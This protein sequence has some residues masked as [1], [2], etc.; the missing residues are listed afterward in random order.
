MSGR[1]GAGRWLAGPGAQLMVVALGLVPLALLVRDAL[2]GGLGVNPVEDITH[3]T[4]DWTLRL[5]LGTLAVTP[6][7][8]L[9]GLGGLTRFRRTLGLLTY[10][11]AWLHFLTFF[12]LDHSLRFDGLAEDIVKRPYI[13]VGFTTFLLLSPL[14]VTSTR[15]WVRRLGGRRWAALHRLVYVAGAGGVLHF[16]WL[17]K[18]VQLTPV[19]YGLVLVTLLALRVWSGRR[20]RAARR[21]ASQSA[22]LS[23]GA[24]APPITHMRSRS[25]TPWTTR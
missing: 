5:L 18:G 20:A 13:T 10:G 8:R 23:A 24:G 12:G 16:L 15:G 7:R 14:A 11:Y 3:R 25:A 9:T 17:V 22:A 21:S 1:A 19:W 4:G 6:L 2:T